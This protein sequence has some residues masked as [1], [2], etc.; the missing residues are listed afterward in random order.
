M[1]VGGLC[2]CCFSASSTCCTHAHR[3][4]DVSVQSMIRLGGGVLVL[5]R[6]PAQRLLS[7][8][9]PRNLG[10]TVVPSMSFG[11]G[12]APTRYVQALG[13]RFQVKGKQRH[14]MSERALILYHWKDV[15]VVFFFQSFL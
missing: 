6:Y 7:A 13:L 15:P 1:L 11:R 3:A 2:R 10:S 8:R 12:L 14:F 9:V 5:K 4:T